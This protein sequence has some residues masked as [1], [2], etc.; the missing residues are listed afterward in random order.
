[1]RACLFRTF[2]TF[3]R[4]GGAE[5]NPSSAPDGLH[6]APPILRALLL[7]LMF[8]TDA[9][10]AQARTLPPPQQTEF[11]QHLN[12][13]LPLQLPFTDS[14]GHRVTL[15]DYFRQRPVVLVLGYYHCPNLCSTL[16][17]G[18]LPALAATGL[19]RDAFRVVEVSIDPSETSGLAARRKVS[20]Q[21]LLGRRGGE[22]HLLTGAAGPISQLA[23]SIGFHYRYDAT[24][25]QYI[26]PAGFLVATPTGRISHYFMGVR[27][28][29]A[30]QVRQALLDASS[31]RIGS[32]VERLLLLCAHY[33]PQ[34]GKY[35]VTVMSAVRAICLLLVLALLGGWAWLQRGKRGVLG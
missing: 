29:D 7:F 17:E 6:S 34:T 18:V 12:T 3:R 10:H 32:P 24:L 26:H 14:T 22:L 13:Q 23:A 8:C 33:D 35:T 4:I 27:F 19:P 15:G 31:N 25:G 2:R 9:A 16:M 28:D 20:Y 11:V 1:M 30:Q 5:C 21:P